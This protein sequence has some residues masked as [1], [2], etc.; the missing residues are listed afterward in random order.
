[1]L[2]KPWVNVDLIKPPRSKRLPDILSVDE[3]AALFMATNKISYRVFYFTLDNLGLRLSEGLNLKLGDI[4]TQRQ[5]VHIRDAK[6]SKDR[7]VPLPDV[8]VGLLR[9]FWHLHR[10][11]V[12]LFPNR[13]RGLQHAHLATTPMDAGV[14]RPLCARWLRPVG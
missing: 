9:R 1:M 2:R 6:G 10:H 12:M 7:F 14:F 3:A 5:R 8:T 4:D 11:P 13:K